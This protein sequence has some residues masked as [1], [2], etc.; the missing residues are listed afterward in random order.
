MLKAEPLDM[1]ATR[2]T[3]C[4]SALAAEIESETTAGHTNINKDA[5]G[6]VRDLMNILFG[7]SLE[8]E[9][10]VN[11]S[12]FD[13]C[14]RDSMRFVQVTSD[15]S[16]TKIQDCL[17][18]TTDRVVADPTLRDFDLDILFLTMNSKKTG[19]LKKKVAEK[20]PYPDSDLSLFGFKPTANLLDFND[21]IRPLRENHVTREQMAQLSELMDKYWPQNAPQPAPTD[22]V[23]EIIEQYAENFTDPLFMH[24][25][26]G[27]VTLKN[28]YVEPTF[29]ESKD[30]HYKSDPDFSDIY[31]HFE[32]DPYS[33]DSDGSVQHLKSLFNNSAAPYRSSATVV[34]TLSDFLWYQPREKI[35][36]IEGDAAIGKTSLVSWM[37]YH[38]MM[39]DSEHQ[40]PF[41]NC[42]VV[43]VRL[44]DLKFNTNEQSADPILQYLNIPN[45]RDF[46]RR[47]PG[48]ILI[49]D[50]ADELG[51]IKSLDADTIEQFIGNSLKSLNVKKLIVTSRPKFLDSSHLRNRLYD[52]RK[53]V[54]LPFNAAKR[55]QWIRNYIAQGESISKN[56]LKYIRTMTDKEAD[57]VAN[58]PLALYLLVQFDWQK[59]FRDNLWSLYHEIF[60]KAITNAYYNSNFF[61]SKQVLDTDE[62]KQN[63]DMVKEIA[64]TM[65][66]NYG[67]NRF[68]IDRRELDQCALAVDLNGADPERVK[69]TCV[70]CAYWRKSSTG[71]L[72]GVLE[73]YH[74][75]IR[76][77][78]LCEYI[79][80]NLLKQIEELEQTPVSAD[81]P[82]WI[83]LVT[84]CCRIFCWGKI[85]NSPWAQVFR[86]INLRLNAEAKKC[87]NHNTLYAKLA[88]NPI[89][90]QL[91][92]TLITTSTMWSEKYPTHPYFVV[93][94]ITENVLALWHIMRNVAQAEL[95]LHNHT[96]VYDPAAS[97]IIKEWNRLFLKPVFI[98]LLG[99]VGLLSH[100]RLHDIDWNYQRIEMADFSRSTL[101]QLSFIGSTL[102]NAVF[103][104]GTLISCNFRD[105]TLQQCTFRSTNMQNCTFSNASL[106]DSFISFHSHFKQVHFSA[107]KLHYFKSSDTNYR[108]CNFSFAEI[109]WSQL[110]KTTFSSCSFRNTTFENVSIEDCSMINCTFYQVNAKNCTY[111]NVHPETAAQLEAIGFTQY[112]K[113]RKEITP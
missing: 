78:F 21:L 3:K 29:M 101:Q 84:L 53:I 39:A 93:K 110:R 47:Y 8:L 113:R 61:G 79:C 100:A 43:C 11:S 58:T 89:L 90:L 1:M 82:A 52:I 9:G 45:A 27:T 30:T 69:K 70:L 2:L 111:R 38:V 31:S 41:H 63:Y 112:S 46:S 103:S 95:S 72:D 36:I 105:S 80:D 65:F 49:L 88:K 83:P 25:D 26:S 91:P 20:L 57:G 107:T 85:I 87:N 34:D 68:Y 55:E 97:D 77:F 76:D 66:R 96:F 37:C 60:S 13:L 109:K 67:S 22:R 7:Y 59:D 17:R 12:G 40:N 62:A 48:A 35:L 106:L 86:M 74:N 44:R 14:D 94:D 19:T 15:Q 42:P 33:V 23:Q 102:I 5:E 75:N 104:D 64:F 73:F 18:T 98:P 108:D 10:K 71:D 99:S 56:T 32:D 81:D 16:T 4:L 6:I 50:G 51:M 24:S 28:M 92:N 54:L